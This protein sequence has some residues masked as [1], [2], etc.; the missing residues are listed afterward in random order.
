MLGAGCSHPAHPGKG[1]TEFPRSQLFHG[2]NPEP[3]LPFVLRHGLNI[4]EPHGETFPSQKSH[5][6]AR[7]GR[8]PGCARGR[9]CPPGAGRAARAGSVSALLRIFMGSPRTPQPQRDGMGCPDFLRLQRTRDGIP[10]D[11]AGSG[12]GGRLVAGLAQR[13]SRRG[14]PQL[15]CRS[16]WQIQMFSWS[17]WINLSSSSSSSSQGFPDPQAPPLVAAAKQSHFVFFLGR[18]G[19][20]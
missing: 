19:R 7:W 1:S 15:I 8:G 9:G 5:A 18:A 4:W 6:G 2:I 20:D 13:G 10:G 3:E 14:I 16:K 17:P 12:N 11:A